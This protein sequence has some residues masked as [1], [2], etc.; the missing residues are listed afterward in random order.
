MIFKSSIFLEA[1]KSGFEL[2]DEQRNFYLRR[3]NKLQT[4]VY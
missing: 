1:E 2:T 4:M 3:V